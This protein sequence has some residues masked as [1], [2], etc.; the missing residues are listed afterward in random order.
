MKV[1]HYASV[2]GATM[3]PAQKSQASNSTHSPRRACRMVLLG[4]SALNEGSRTFFLMT[5]MKKGG[6]HVYRR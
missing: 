3:R 2:A 1:G 4:R 5:D 6:R